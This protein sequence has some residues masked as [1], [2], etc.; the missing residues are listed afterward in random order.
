MKYLVTG[1]N[2]QL[3]YDVVREL[4]S[5]GVTED[6]II[7]VGHQEMDITD[8]ACVHRIITETKPDVVFHN[9]AY[10]KVDL[11]EEHCEE[12][13]KVNSLGPKYIAEACKEIGAKL[14]YV[15]TDYVFDGEK[16]GI[17]N[18]MDQPNAQNVYGKTKYLGELNAQ[19]NPKTYIVRVSWVFGIHGNNFV[20]TM[21]R[22]SES[23]ESVS[24]VNDQFGS[25]TY[26]VDLAR[27]LVE[28]SEEEKYEIYHATNDGFCNWAEYAQ[29]ILKDTNTVVQ[30]VS[31]EEYYQP[32]YAKAKMEGKVLKIATRPKCSKLSK[33]KLQLN[34][35]QPLPRWEDAVDRFKVELEKEKKLVR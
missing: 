8:E 4:K 20:K 25:P 26:T 29:Y 21:L 34:G 24:V 18:E 6:D 35:F 9:A 3:G 7:A 27:L 19:I 28:M 31:T 10:T 12:C 11:A 32:Q 30:P 2:G 5:R 17:Y 13:Y 16:D 33:V 1:V 15:S 14:I 23:K 22:L